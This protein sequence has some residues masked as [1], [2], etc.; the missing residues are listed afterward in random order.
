MFD[1]GIRGLLAEVDDEIRRL[2]ASNRVTPEMAGSLPLVAAGYAYAAT[3]D[4]GHRARCDAKDPSSAVYRQLARL[5]PWPVEL[6]SPR[7]DM[8]RAAALLVLE[9]NRLAQP[10]ATEA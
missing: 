9:L 3:L 4:A 1:P 7:H 8:L 6:R 2:R 10:V 5:C